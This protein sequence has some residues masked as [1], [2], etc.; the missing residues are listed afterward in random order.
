MTATP[1]TTANSPSTASSAASAAASTTK[2]KASVSSTLNAFLSLL[3]TQLKN[4]D[5]LHATDANQF[6]QELIQINTLE[7]QVAGNTSLSSIDGKLS[8]LSSTS[9]LSSGVGY[10]GRTVKAT[11]ADS[12]LSSGG[13]ATWTYNL[14][15]QSASTTLTVTDTAGTTVWTGAGSTTAGNNS[16]VWDGTKTDGTK[17]P[18]GSYTLKVNALN[19]KQVAI[20]PTISG[21]GVVTGVTSV[22]GATQLVLGGSVTVPISSVTS[23]TQ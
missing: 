4:Q 5:P 11:S 2:D 14:P 18:S 7:Q 20:T 22:S 6:T 8:T 3:T 17:A 1:A 10:I 15:T 13:S 9:A 12:P 23:I 21:Q 19:S 16:F